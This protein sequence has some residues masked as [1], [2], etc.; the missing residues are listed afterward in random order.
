MRWTPKPDRLIPT[1]L[2]GALLMG[3]PDA[4]DGPRYLGA[5]SKKPIEGGT[6]QIASS[7]KVRTLDPHIGFDVVSGTAL[8]LLYEGLL[9][10]NTKTELV[11]ALATS[12]PSISE[13]GRTF[14]FELRKG[15]RFQVVTHQQG[16]PL[17]GKALQRVG[18]MPLAGGAAFQ[19]GDE[20]G[21]ALGGGGHGNP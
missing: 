21:K 5:G 20:G 10:Y 15:Q 19:M 1:L 14:I 4:P 16:F 18:L 9:N 2:L 7:T 11:P 17:A 6:L 3:C 12:L 13:D 8:E